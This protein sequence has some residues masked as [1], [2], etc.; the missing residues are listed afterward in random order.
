MHSG[1]RRKRLDGAECGRALTCVNGTRM[2]RGG[3]SNV[4]GGV[5]SCQGI[6]A[7]SGSTQR[8]LDTA[9]QLSSCHAKVGGPTAFGRPPESNWR[10]GGRQGRRR[11]GQQ[12]RGPRAAEAGDVQGSH[13][14]GQG[15]GG[16]R[17]DTWRPCSDLD[18]G[19]ADPADLG[20]PASPPG[21]RHEEH[22]ELGRR[23]APCQ[24]DS[25]E[26]AA[27]PPRPAGYRMPSPCGKPR[28]R[29]SLPGRDGVEVT[30]P[31]GSTGGLP[32]GRGDVSDSS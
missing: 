12:W 11:G 8:A 18:G 6:P 21:D 1:R 10:N 26:A 31:R 17:P 29:P 3:P 4:S 2:N 7:L 19:V 9:V 14:G 5:R 30:G 24:P 32:R 16:R 23:F 25:G 28:L 15:P 20:P 27:Q 22:R 13:T